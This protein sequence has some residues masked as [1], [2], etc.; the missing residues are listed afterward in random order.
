MRKGTDLAG[1]G[2][3]HKFMNSKIISNW[4][5]EIYFSKS[6][7]HLGA[8]RNCCPLTMVPSAPLAPVS[9]P[10]PAADAPASL[11]SPIL[12]TRLPMTMSE[13]DKYSIKVVKYFPYKHL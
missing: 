1:A 2:G 6:F 4:L 13:I 9:A 7:S 3:A 10:G 11:L 5:H 8:T 12:T